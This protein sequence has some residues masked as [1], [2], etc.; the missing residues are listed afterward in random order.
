V[1]VL[2]MIACQENLISYRFFLS[3]Q[4]SIEIDAHFG[5]DPYLIGISSS[6]NRVQ[7]RRH[8]SVATKNFD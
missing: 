5:L 7:L 8:L 3:H 4:S 1:D 2:Y 6:K